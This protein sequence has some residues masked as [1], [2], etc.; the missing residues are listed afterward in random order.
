MPG[1][2]GN[3]SYNNGNNRS[4][5]GSSKWKETN[6]FTNPYNFVALGKKCIRKPYEEYKKGNLKTGWIEC[7]LITKTPLF[8]PNTTN[9]NAFMCAKKGHKSYDFFSYDDI[10][11]QDRTKQFSDP[12]IPASSIRGAIRAMY[13]AV[14]DSCMSTADDEKILYKRTPTPKLPGMLKKDDQGWYIHPCER[15]MLKYKPCT[16]DPE[17]ILV[18]IGDYHEGQEVYIRKSKNHYD[19]KPYMPYTVAE[20]YPKTD[21]SDNKDNLLKIQNNT[22]KSNDNPIIVGHVHIGEEIYNKHHESVFVLE[23]NLKDNDRIRVKEEDVESLRKTLKLYN[24]ENI[25]LKLKEERKQNKGR[26]WYKEYEVKEGALVYYDKD[27]IC[28]T[29]SCISKEVFS[30]QLKQILKKSGE[31]NNKSGEDKNKNN[32]YNPC[33]SKEVCPSCALFGMIADDG[34]ENTAISSRLRF[35]DA[36]AELKSNKNEYYDKITIL[37][38]LASPKVS[39]TEF[40]MEEPSIRPDLWNY[41]YAI[42][43]NGNIPE[44][45]KDYKPRIRGRKFYWHSKKVLTADEPTE[46]NSTVRPVRAGVTFTFK[47]YFDRINEEELKKLVWTLT[48][49]SN[50]NTNCHKMGKGKPIGLGSVKIKVDKVIERK[51]EIKNN[52]LIRTE[53]EITVDLE[54]AVVEP[55]SLKEPPNIKE[56]LKITDFSKAPNNVRYPMGYT[57]KDGKNGVGPH[58]WFIANKSFSNPPMKPKIYKTLPKILDSKTTL[59]DYEM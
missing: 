31:D 32:G 4:Y 10:K 20:I 37:E 16:S 15:V 24:D 23:E 44:R 48:L 25:N 13:E 5:G 49:G 26:K 3:R 42:N 51:V 43:W 59:N 38:E 29:P 45:V 11:G 50:E 55:T 6:E 1:Y 17:G 19:N 57:K 40:Y 36:Q 2:N 28:M 58:Q 9:E 21:S 39:A 47:V 7:S 54:N 56:I 8:I 18:K 30:N 22:S 12:V 52:T 46:R 35:T 53:N 34:K 27:R 14:T 33:S 41:D